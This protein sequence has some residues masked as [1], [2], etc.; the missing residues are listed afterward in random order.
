MA[1]HPDA[2]MTRDKDDLEG[3]VISELAASTRGAL[4][5]KELARA[6]EIPPSDYRRFRRLLTGLERSGKIYRRSRHLSARSTRVP[7]C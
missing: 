5:G 4:K 7:R 3:R 1:E 6:L 2:S